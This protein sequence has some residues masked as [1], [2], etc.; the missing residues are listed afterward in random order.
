MLGKVRAGRRGR[1]RPACSGGSTA[2]WGHRTGVERTWNMLAM[3][4]TL[5]VFQLDMSALK[6]F[7]PRKSPLMSVTFETSQSAMVPYVA[8]ASAGLALYAWTAA[9]REAV[10][11]KA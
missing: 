5:E 2:D 9:F 8:V 3:V 10:L 11:V 4:V 7:W 6:A 1:R